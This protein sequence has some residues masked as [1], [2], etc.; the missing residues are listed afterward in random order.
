MLLCFKTC[1][2][3]P[4]NQNSPK[5]PLKTFNIQRKQGFQ[6]VLESEEVHFP[7][8]FIWRLLYFQ[9]TILLFH[10]IP[11]G[12][13]SFSDSFRFLLKSWNILNDLKPTIKDIWIFLFLVSLI[14]P[15]QS[16]LPNSMKTYSGPHKEL[17]QNK[18][19]LFRVILSFRSWFHFF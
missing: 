2:K 18:T 16:T 5:K 19:G 7:F 14:L 11:L 8:K 4:F 6:E 17:I 1:W 10:T 3:P 15:T 13:G 12:L 9:L